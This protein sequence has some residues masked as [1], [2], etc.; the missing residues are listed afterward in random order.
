[1]PR[2]VYELTATG[3]VQV[4]R[5]FEQI[6]AAAK[7]AQAQ[8]PGN[9][10][11]S[12]R[13]F[14]GIGQAAELNLKKIDREARRASLGM[15]AVNASMRELRSASATTLGALGP[16]GNVLG[17]LTLAGGVAGA[18][19]AGV[20]AIAGA[21]FIGAKR[22][23]DFADALDDQ[24]RA[25]GIGV[26]TLQEYQYVAQQTGVANET[27][28]RSFQIFTRNFG[29]LQAG[30]GELSKALEKMDSG[31][32]QQVQTATSVDEALNLVIDRIASLSSVQEQAVL[33]QAAFGRGGKDLVAAFAAGKLTIQ[34]LREEIRQ[35]GGVMGKDAVD[36]GSRASDAF[37]RL[38][39]VLKAQVK[40]AFLGLSPLLEKVFD[41]MTEIASFSPLLVKVGVEVED[42]S[43]TRLERRL[44]DLR[45]QQVTL[46]GVATGPGAPAGQAVG[47]ALGGPRTAA[48][49]DAGFSSRLNAFLAAAQAQGYGVSVKSGYRPEER[50]AQL[51]A[52]ALAKYGSADAARK[53]VAPPGRSA[54]GFGMAADLAFHGPSSRA[55]AHENAGRFG[56]NFRMANEPWHVEPRGYR[57]GASTSPGGYRGGQLQQVGREIGETETQLRQQRG[58]KQL[59]DSAAAV[60]QSAKV[61]AAAR[62]A[63][64][65]AIEELDKLF[66]KTTANRLAELDTL[67]RESN[68]KLKAALKTGAL[69]Q[70][71]YNK[72]K[73]DYDR[74]Y[75]EER[76]QL[77]DQSTSKER[78]AA[79]KLAQ[80]LGRFREQ[81]ATA[82]GK[83]ATAGLTGASQIRAQAEET[84]RAFAVE[85]RSRISDAKQAD[86]LIAAFR[87][88][89]MAEAEAEITK[90]RGEQAKKDE[91]QQ[92]DVAQRI[93]EARRD[94]ASAGL[95]G[96]AKILADAEKEIAA[97]TEYVKG[98]ISDTK[99]AE[100]AV[101]EYRVAV[102]QKADA[103]I[104]AYRSDEAEKRIKEDERAAKEAQSLVDAQAREFQ[105]VFRGVGSALGDSISGA[106]V[107]AE[108]QAQS[109]TDVIRN[110]FAGLAN[111]LVSI[112]LEKSIFQPLAQE[113]AGLT[114]GTS[115]SGGSSGV[116]GILGKL[117]GGSS[118]ATRGVVEG[119]LPTSGVGPGSPVF[120]DSGLS[121]LSSSADEA[122]SSLLGMAGKALTVAGALAYAGQQI[123]GGRS[124]ISDA[125]Y[126]QNA[127]GNAYTA[128]AAVFVAGFA[129]GG[130]AIGS[131]VPVIG[132]AIGAAVGAAVGAALSS[133]LKEELVN[134]IDA[135]VKKGLDQAGL[136]KAVVKNLQADPLLN[137]LSGGLNTVVAPLLGPLFTPDIERIFEKILR[138]TLGGTGGYSTAG[139]P[140]DPQG[141]SGLRAN[142][143]QAGLA[144][145]IIGQG[146]G[147]GGAALDEDRVAR[148]ARLLLAITKREV[149]RDD[150]TDTAAATL[151]DIF[152]SAFQGSFLDA[153]DAAN[154]SIKKKRPEA[155]AFTAGQFTTAADNYGFDY[156]L[157]ADVVA[158]QE[159]VPTTVGEGGK[160]VGTAVK[161]SRDAFKEAFT[162][163]LADAADSSVFRRSMAKSLE[164]AFA[165]KAAQVLDKA[166]GSLFAPFFALS[167][168]AKRTFRKA[169]RRGNFPLALN[170]LTDDY[171][172]KTREFAAIVTQPA[173]ATALTQLSDAMLRLEVATAIAAGSSREAADAIESRLAPAIA[174]VKDTAQLGRDVRSRSALALAGPGFAGDRAQ[175][176]ELRRVRQ[177]AEA[178]FNAKTGGFDQL[179]RDRI[180]VLQRNSPAAPFTS[181]GALGDPR[182]LLTD[183][184]EYADAR[185]SELEGEISLQRQLYETLKAAAEAFGNL[186]EQADLAL[187]TVSEGQVFEKQVQKA[188][189]AYADVLTKGWENSD[190]VSALQSALGA[191]IST[192]IGRIDAFDALKEQ[193]DDLGRSIGE[194]LGQRDATTRLRELFGELRL[195]IE[196]T[197]EALTKAA[198][199][200]QEAVTLASGRRDFF[201]GA[202][203]DFGSFAESADI[204]QRGKRGQRDALAERRAEITQLLGVARAGGS[205]AT[206]AITDLRRLLPEALSLGQQTLSGGRFRALAAELERAGLDLEQFSKTQ[207]SVAE[208]QLTELQAIALALGASAADGAT[209]ARTQLELLQVLAADAE[210][211]T[212]SASAAALAALEAAKAELIAFREAIQPTIEYLKGLAGQTLSSDFQR[213]ADLLSDGPG[214]KIYAVLEQ[215]RNRLPEVKGSKTSGEPAGTGP[216]Y[217]TSDQGAG[218]FL[219]QSSTATQATTVTVGQ[220]VVTFQQPPKS[221][222]EARE[223][224][225]MIGDAL[226]ERIQQ[227]VSRGT[228]KK[229]A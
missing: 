56:L 26:E 106:L 52:A 24:A 7:R 108:G 180:E 151:S 72:L 69:D 101:A 115:S 77:V 15:H 158:R 48:G 219:P 73:L 112:F 143:P 55:W 179:E 213:L 147:A 105:G 216:A 83:A 193:F 139:I 164:T 195:G 57:P 96:E 200:V 194:T 163:A 202:T 111:D 37:S 38:A 120:K 98:K 190:A 204:A 181:P 212:G 178:R 189:A 86:T 14:E 160:G 9:G 168:T 142:A 203:S 208:Q 162:A 12:R 10:G 186:R 148:F 146:I 199:Q 67:W 137:I 176:D 32:K 44:E 141:Y 113:L 34:Q 61:T 87:T 118:G 129:A 59:A 214:G 152:V 58:A 228:L 133:A 80:D 215:V 188:Q 223:Y 144:A 175:V 187:K 62:K 5:L 78:Q 121:A 19:V 95:E 117:V 226:T 207:V 161:V 90:D 153:L 109:T 17:S 171:L 2:I 177:E 49:L 154:K 167:K 218:Q 206:E 138:Q 29:L 27:L 64:A 53:W 227:V 66:P 122:S 50:Q 88:A 25:I 119:P 127:P 45:R 225:R 182:Q 36:A 51:W 85:V 157:L 74:R 166:F 183:L 150:N 30:T 210:G 100:A 94:A 211:K 185:L 35:L 60:E 125:S 224:G 196:Q 165:G 229:V 135:S 156:Q 97:F 81:I 132:T 173:F 123:A 3:G 116:L 198:G 75:A 222:A 99:Q 184:Q 23:A 170:T 79:E 89:K 91:D 192:A 217:I 205:K 191:A 4:A 149:A 136:D 68:E 174:L 70:D 124:E 128:Q 107:G 197:P 39:S 155:F 43:I 41:Q 84:V 220:V 209:D 103:E 47:T 16:V 8:L 104:T 22:A 114:S 140:I 13:L 71:E 102:S 65:E 54:H 63:A 201:R 21:L 40:G 110:L 20:T 6:G 221:Q 126:G 11:E 172:K 1:V 18:A 31:F 76:Q 134:G 46:G 145:T 130:A 169:R 131:A 33:A 159:R 82:G 93:A 42:D 28:T 92:K